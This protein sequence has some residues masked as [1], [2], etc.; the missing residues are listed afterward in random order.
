[1]LYIN[2]YCTLSSSF[3]ISSEYFW[4]I[5]LKTLLKWIVSS[6]ATANFLTSSSSQDNWS[7]GC[8][9]EVLIVESLK[10][11][12][13][14]AITLI[15]K[16]FYVV[17]KFGYE[18]SFITWMFRVWESSNNLLWLFKTW[19]IFCSLSLIRAC[20]SK[21]CSFCLKDRIRSYLQ[22]FP[23]V[24]FFPYAINKWLK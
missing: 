16:M 5:C 19:C 22:R 15:I 17:I 24:L 4:V 2:Y 7:G 11:T 18:C 6:S 20:S 12:R 14:C 21:I 9:R 8:L 23:P 1:M 13:T 3:L 10:M